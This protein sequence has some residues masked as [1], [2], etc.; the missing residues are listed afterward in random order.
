MNAPNVVPFRRDRDDIVADLREGLRSLGAIGEQ[1]DHREPNHSDAA[2]LDALV[3]G[4]SRVLVELR[5]ALD[6]PRLLA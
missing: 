1:F 2:S 6:P 5:V 4:V 3:R